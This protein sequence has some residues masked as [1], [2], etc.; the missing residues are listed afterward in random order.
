[1]TFKTTSHLLRWLVAQK[2]LNLPLSMSVTH[3]TSSKNYWE[4]RYTPIGKGSGVMY[5]TYRGFPLSTIFGAWKKIIWLIR[6]TW[7][8]IYSAAGRWKTFGVPVVIGGDNLPSPVRTG[9]TDLTNIGGANGPPGP[10]G[11]GPNGYNCKKKMF[12]CFP[13]ISMYNI[14]S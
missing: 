9:L 2:L 5:T 3:C 8:C 7:D 12:F 10:P 11:S 14:P 6:T 13:F 4:V 1:M